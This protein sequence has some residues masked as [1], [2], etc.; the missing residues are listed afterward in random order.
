MAE[1][2]FRLEIITPEKVIYSGD[3]LSIIAPGSEGYMGVLPR[4]A[5]LVTSLKAGSLKIKEPQQK[6]VIFNLISGFME[7]RG[8][9]VDVLVDNKLES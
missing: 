2:T 7:V 6:E 4:H 8:D 1:K 3:V 9:R 5:P